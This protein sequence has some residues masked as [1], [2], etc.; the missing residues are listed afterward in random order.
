MNDKENLDHEFGN[1]L[2]DVV[3][4]SSMMTQF[5]PHLRALSADEVFNEARGTALARIV[6]AAPERK[7]IYS[8]LNKKLVNK[9]IEF[10]EILSEIQKTA[11][12]WG[13]DQFAQT[14]RGEEIF[15]K[16]INENK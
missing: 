8:A 1:L 7:E 5:L 4:L 10:V 12:V 14:V 2:M 9:L 3:T 15:N 11:K 16:I 13:G 6:N